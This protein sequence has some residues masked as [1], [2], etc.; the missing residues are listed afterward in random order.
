MK[1]GIFIVTWSGGVEQL[2]LL[3]FSLR[4]YHR[5]PM[6]LLLN[7]AG[8]APIS[9]FGE[10]TNNFH[11]IA[12]VHDTFECGALKSAMELTDLDEF[13]ILQDTIEVLNPRIFQKMFEYEGQSVTFGPKFTLYL[14]KYRRE[15]LNKVEI[16]VTLTKIEA[17]QTESTFAMTYM[18]AEDR[19][20]ITLFPEFDDSNPDNFIEKR[21]GRANLV[22]KNRYL[23]KRKGT[24]VDE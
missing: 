10:L 20:I 17:I 11:I 1:Q 15:T 13:I 16:P 8:K 7:D 21:W 3:L 14:A 19:E 4:N 5:Y 22:L 12:S 23:I 18:A 24:W 9:Y 6:Y 2:S